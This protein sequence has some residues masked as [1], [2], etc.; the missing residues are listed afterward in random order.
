MK[1]EKKRQNI[2]IG[3]DFP[4]SEIAEPKRYG[5]D[6]AR[7]WIALCV[8]ATFLGIGIGGALSSLNSGDHAVFQAVFS[9]MHPF[10]G[11]LIGYYFGRRGQGG[12]IDKEDDESAA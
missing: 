7:F 4:L 11:I 2:S 8:L 12:H 6:R 9:S 10:V 1:V 3:E 5:D